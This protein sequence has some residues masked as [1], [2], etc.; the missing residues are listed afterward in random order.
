MRC[1]DGKCAGIV[2]TCATPPSK[3]QP[4]AVTYS[5]DLT[6][7]ADAPAPPAQFSF[8]VV[9]APTE[10][11][12]SER[13]AVVTI[14]LA[15]FSHNA[16]TMQFTV[17]P[18]ADSLLCDIHFHAWSEPFDFRKRIFSPV[19]DLILQSYLPEPFAEPIFLQFDIPS[20]L[21]QDEFMHLC[22][23]RA[24]GNE[25]TCEDGALSGQYSDEAKTRV[26]AVGARIN[27]FGRYALLSTE[28]MQKPHKPHAIHNGGANA[29][30]YFIGFA[31]LAPLALCLCGAL[32]V[33]VIWRVRRKRLH[34]KQRPVEQG[35]DL[36]TKTEEQ[37]A[38][39]GGDMQTAGAV[40]YGSLE[41]DEA[42]QPVPLHAPMPYGG[43]TWVIGTQS[44]ETQTGN[45]VNEFNE[46]HIR[47]GPPAYVFE[48]GYD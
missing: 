36:A 27:H 9:S 5:V 8:D 32:T 13:I 47:F 48:R 34:A 2:E 31:I 1:W 19:L 3:I 44:V 21:T 17:R 20:E 11:R 7:S 43:Y 25:W 28:K 39:A 12:A 38:A 40:T 18:V 15:T 46:Q 4:I 29:K 6:T 41:A 37:T 35:V 10:S 30:L 33:F 23:G 22:L 45:H 26:S 14:P 42:S 24:T 16:N